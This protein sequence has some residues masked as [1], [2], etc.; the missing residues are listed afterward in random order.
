MLIQQILGSLSLRA[1]SFFYIHRSTVK[2][3]LFLCS[4]NAAIPCCCVSAL[5]YTP[6]LYYGCFFVCR[7][8]GLENWPNVDIRWYT[9]YVWGQPFFLVQSLGCTLWCCQINF[10]QDIL[11]H[12]LH[13]SL[14][15]RTADMYRPS[16]WWCR[17]RRFG[18]DKIWIGNVSTRSW[19]LLFFLMLL[20]KHFLSF[21]WF[22][23]DLGFLR[24]STRLHLLHRDA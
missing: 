15:H 19:D 4:F 20:G 7:H 21:Y 23:T 9:A 18:P 3:P 22:V 11:V 8:Q 5:H 24:D 12:C 1:G 17:T 6:C 10:V 16:S 14:L 2:L 13:A